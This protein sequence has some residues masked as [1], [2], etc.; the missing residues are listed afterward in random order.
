[1][2]TD[3]FINKDGRLLERVGR[4]TS[5]QQL[6]EME[7][8]ETPANAVTPEAMYRPLDYT[9]EVCF[10]TFRGTPNEQGNE[11][12]E[13]AAEFVAGKLQHLKRIHTR[14]SVAR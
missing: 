13:Y 8:L 7:D 2:L 3:Y 1:M 6:A 10:Y 5:E 11:W 4:Y 14:G 9:G 12:F